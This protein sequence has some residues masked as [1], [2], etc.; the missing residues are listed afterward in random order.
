M[1]SKTQQVPAFPVP[2]LST[3][4]T[5]YAQAPVKSL[6]EKTKLAAMV[7]LTIVFLVVIAIGLVIAATQ[8]WP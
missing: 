3:V 7:V 4:K 5:V 2:T 8:G 6:G 1:F